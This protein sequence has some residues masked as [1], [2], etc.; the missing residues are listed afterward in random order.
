MRR[1]VL[2]H[3]ALHLW[4]AVIGMRTHRLRQIVLTSAGFTAFFSSLG[5]ATDVI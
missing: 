4:N 2:V 3:Y 5:V 1:K